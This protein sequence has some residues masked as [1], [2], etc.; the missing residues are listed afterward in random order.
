M[1]ICSCSVMILL[2]PGSFMPPNFWMCLS[3]NAKPKWQVCWQPLCAFCP[4]LPKIF[5]Q[6]AKPIGTWPK[7]LPRLSITN[8]FVWIMHLLGTCR[9]QQVRLAFIYKGRAAALPHG[10]V[11]CCQ[12]ITKELWNEITSTWN[13]CAMSAFADL[14][15]PMIWNWRHCIPN[16]PQY[17]VL[18][19]PIALY[20]KKDW[21]LHR[22]FPNISCQIC[23]FQ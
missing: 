22:R 9:A 15:C 10:S 17:Y 5:Q 13:G 23:F 16:N 1:K 14:S 4:V 6:M 20:Y 12:F 19:P 2:S 8:V 3:H 7:D 21:W 11:L 18:L